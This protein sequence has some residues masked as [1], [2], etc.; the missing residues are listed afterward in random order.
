[1][2]SPF[3]FL[4]IARLRNMIYIMLWF[5]NGLIQL[6]SIQN[7]HLENRVVTVRLWKPMIEGHVRR[8]EQEEAE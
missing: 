4:L 7:Q 1:M 2:H 8:N 3:H 5:T 6:K